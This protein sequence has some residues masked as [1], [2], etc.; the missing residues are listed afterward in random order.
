MPR[1]RASASPLFVPRKA[2]RAD[3]RAA[4]MVRRRT[5]PAELHA[6][7]TGLVRR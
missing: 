5:T 3:Q 1:T 7:F 6:P 4:H 2:S